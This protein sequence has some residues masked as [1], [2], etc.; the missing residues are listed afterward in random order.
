[1]TYIMKKYLFYLAA[2]MLLTSSCQMQQEQENQ[3][4]V[5][6]KLLIATL[7]H[8]KSAERDALCY[9]AYNVARMHL[10]EILR[11]N[12]NPEK[13]AIVLDLDET[14]LDN[15]PYEAKCVLD[16]ISYP[17][18][19]DEWMH[20]ADAAAIPGSIDFLD[21]AK[22]KGIEIFYITN[23]KEKYREATQQ[24]LDK[25]G[26]APKSEN[27]LLLRKE[28]SS[29]ETRRNQ[30]LKDHEIVMLFGDNLADFSSVFN[31]Q[32]TP[33]KRAELV[34][35]LKNEFGSRFIAFPN[36]MYG[37]WLNAL[38]EYDFSLSPQEQTQLKKT[39]L[40]SF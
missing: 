37:E 6:E 31:G 3:T 21:Y 22:S 29:K 18:G 38:I 12:D 36:A 8:Q 32:H 17:T 35:D 27:H 15:S 2:A 4:A 24:N 20:A 19:W 33:E 9:Q 28:E 25:L 7:Y 13:L 1:M 30:V 10:D 14:V 40:E 39:R 23:R 11:E 26:I 16:N 5:N 34:K